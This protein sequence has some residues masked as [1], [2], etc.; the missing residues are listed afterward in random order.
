MKK[1]GCMNIG[2]IILCCALLVGCTFGPNTTTPTDVSPN[3]SSQVE[4]HENWSIDNRKE[5]EYLFGIKFG[6]AII[7]DIRVLHDANGSEVISNTKVGIIVENVIEDCNDIP[8]AE[9]GIIGSHKKGCY[10]HQPEKSEDRDWV[11]NFT[12][13]TIFDVYPELFN[14]YYSEVDNDIVASITHFGQHTVYTDNWVGE[15]GLVSGQ[16]GVFWVTT[17]ISTRENDHNT[18]KEYMIIV[19][20]RIRG[21][22]EIGDTW[23]SAE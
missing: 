3:V 13:E 10:K 8:Y 21:K 16:T 2:C 11:L 18:N 12:L 5:I 19:L 15:N 4:E 23:N 9:I 1:T 20:D 14:P 7:H 17:P 6:D 22:A